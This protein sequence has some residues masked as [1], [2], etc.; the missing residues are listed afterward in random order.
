MDNRAPM[1]LF[2][3]FI[4]ITLPWL[5]PFSPGPSSAVVPLLFAW[6]CA[7][8]LLLLWA[9]AHLKSQRPDWVSAMAGAW[10]AAAGVSAVIGL[11]QYFGA[12]AWLGQWVNHT[13][14]GEAYGNLRQRNQFATLMN[15][16]LVALLWWVA[17]AADPRHRFGP[18]QPGA[19]GVLALALAVLLG[20]GNAVSSSRTGLLQLLLVVVLSL[21]WQHRTRG[22][23]A[24][25]PA[26]QA[27][28]RVLLAAV[29]SYAVATWALPWL[30]GLDPLNSGAW[31]RLRSGDAV[32]SSRLTLWRNVLYLIA[33]K[34]WLGWGW[35]ELDYA[36]F[37]TLYPGARFCDILD[38]AHNLPLHLAVELGVPVAAVLCGCGLW[39]I[40]RARPWRER[41]V[42]RQM[43]WAIL[44]VILL[45]SL[46]EYPLWYGP[47]QMAAG[48]CVWL[49]VSNNS[50][51][52]RSVAPNLQAAGAGVLLA[53]CA[54]AGWQ[55]HMASQIYL[56]P[57]RRAP[58]YRNNTLDKLRDV[59]LYQ[60]HVRFA[61][62]TTTEL[63]PDNAA[64][65]NLL[66][67]E[68]LHFSPEATVAESVIDSARL[69]GRDAEAA[70]YLARLQ[71]AFPKDHADWQQRNLRQ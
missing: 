18:R 30:A 52:K 9:S 62:L 60:D 64:Q 50:P 27:L 23:G 34:P 17:Q 25:S 40:W 20:T 61:K 66:A 37:I 45:H 11:L 48:L 43:A 15:I 2:A 65:M 32:C 63:T 26:G 21:Y 54:L 58:A 38:N 16:G 36:H 57:E 31:A 49:L 70:F 69:L 12:S 1:R 29:L 56:P 35:G 7:A 59:W 5:N 28:Q 51:H 33:Q 14:M 41:D 10:L 68:M 22:H 67:K 39:L 4:L 44:A 8:G 71:A 6:V 46:L 53:F 13:G 3:A 42:S 55:Y 47:F 19:T 24:S